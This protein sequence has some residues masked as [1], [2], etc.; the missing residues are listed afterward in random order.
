MISATSSAQNASSSVAAPLTTRMSLIGRL[1]VSVVPKS[2][3]N[4]PF[5]YSQYCASSGRSNPAAALRSAIC[6]GVSRPPAAAV[7]GSPMPR[8]RKN[9]NVTRNQAVGMISRARTPR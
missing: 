6:A 2:P 7:I 9:T 5:R 8:I 4:N 1:S 3:W